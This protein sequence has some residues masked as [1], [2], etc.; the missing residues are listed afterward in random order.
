MVQSIVLVILRLQLCSLQVTHTIDDL[1]V[2]F[3]WD[4]NRL[5]DKEA[6]EDYLLL[7]LTEPTA[8]VDEVTV[9]PKNKW[10]P[11]ALDTVELEKLGSRKLKINAKTVL[12]IAEKLYQQGYISYPRTETNQFSKEIN[13]RLAVRNDKR[14]RLV[15]MLFTERS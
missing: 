2:E 15:L 4:R 6:C 5:F 11:V 13:L 1:T 12:S 8:R 3:N 10:R 7:C 9:K 14:I